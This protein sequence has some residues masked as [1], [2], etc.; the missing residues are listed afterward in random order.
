MGPADRAGRGRACSEVFNDWLERKWIYYTAP[1][2]NK[3]N[4]LTYKVDWSG[5]VGPT[6]VFGGDE[7]G[8]LTCN[9]VQMPSSD[10]QG[11]LQDLPANRE[12]DRWGQPPH[13]TPRVSSLLWMARP[14]Q[15]GLIGSRC[16][17][18]WTHLK[19]G[20]SSASGFRETWGVADSGRWLE[21]LKA[22]QGQLEVTG[23][24]ERNANG[25][26]RAAGIICVN[27]TGLKTD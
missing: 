22:F 5:E 8:G 4:A 23:K 24:G 2:Y 16:I 15:R 21:T 3:T 7:G 18:L 11:P 19:H 1:F 14:W 26:L 6:H 12:R 13:L 9:D 20:P 17:K 25:E 27:Q 10:C